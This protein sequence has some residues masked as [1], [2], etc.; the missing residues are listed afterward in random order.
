MLGKY[1]HNYFDNYMEKT[2]KKKSLWQI[3][4]DGLEAIHEKLQQS[5]FYTEF[6]AISAENHHRQHSI[7]L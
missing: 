2:Y 4:G 5:S 1:A 7:D 3:K 6:D